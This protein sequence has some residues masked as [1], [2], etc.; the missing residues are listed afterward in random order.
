M[1]SCCRTE[2]LVESGI[3]CHC[4]L[5]CSVVDHILG[6]NQNVG[7]AVGFEGFVNG[8]FLSVALFLGSCGGVDVS[9]FVL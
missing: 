8:G 2:I 1:A 3:A 9:D 7:V 5:A 6:S 4:D